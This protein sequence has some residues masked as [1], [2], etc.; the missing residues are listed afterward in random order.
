V[1]SGTN[2]VA[3]TN[4]QSGALCRIYGCVDD[5]HWGRPVPTGGPFGGGLTMFGPTDIMLPGGGM[6]Q[7]DRLVILPEGATPVT[8]LTAVTILA[9]QIPQIVITNEQILEIGRPIFTWVGI[10]TYTCQL[11]GACGVYLDAPTDSTG[12]SRAIPTLAT[13]IKGQ[14]Q[15]DFLGEPPDK[16]NLFIISDDIVLDTATA[17]A[18]LHQ[19]VIIKAGA[20][21]VDYSVN[22]H[23]QVTPTTSVQG[24]VIGGTFT[25][26]RNRYGCKKFG[27]CT[28]DE[29][30]IDWDLRAD[31]RQVPGALSWVN[32]HLMVNLLAEP[33]DK[34]NVLTIDDDIVLSPVLAQ[35]LGYQHVTIR[36]GDYAVGYG[37]NSH[38]TFSPDTSAADVTIGITLSI[39]RNRY[40]CLKFGI[41]TLDEVKIDIDLSSDSRIVPG[42][43]TWVNGGLVISCLAE[44]PDKTNVLTIDDDIVLSPALAQSLGLPHATLH[45]GEYPVDYSANP[46]G[47]FSPNISTV[48][49][50]IGQSPDGTLALSW[51]A[52][53][54]TF[55]LMETTD[56]LASPPAWTPV[57]N[58]PTV[59]NG[60]YQVQL[61]PLRSKVYYRLER[62][63]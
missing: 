46:H 40:H 38:G 15:L 55:S 18:L 29:I 32:G 56:L 25:I 4:G 10:R 24:F 27:I 7:G 58:A 28:V 60:T 61:P 13:W 2:L 44:P 54:T 3:S 6:T 48:T 14:L 21:P 37:T 22:P 30:D 11:Y 33:P 35:S 50:S 45:A 16:T 49:L 51:P 20:Y 31:P 9:S 53:P 47:Q 17:Q 57:T 42:G 36:A 52:S 39:G 41:C 34:T 59:V 23:G 43:L 1:Y 8:S 5:D 63:Q 19:Q 26:G 62:H 12:S